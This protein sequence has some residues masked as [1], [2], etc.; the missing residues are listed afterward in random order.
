MARRV[1]SSG[2]DQNRLHGDALPAQPP[3]VPLGLTLHRPRRDRKETE[4]PSQSS[5]LPAAPGAGLP[6]P[7]AQPGRFALPATD[8]TLRH[9]PEQMKDG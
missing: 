9:C 3:E 7:F 1:Q 2:R 6:P 5:C 8:S 4:V